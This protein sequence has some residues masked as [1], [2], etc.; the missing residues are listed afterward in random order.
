[1]GY[2][3]MELLLDKEDK[4]RGNLSKNNSINYFREGQVYEG[5]FSITMTGN[6][7]LVF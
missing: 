3:R 2:L 1:M 5:I 4:F 7:I 6:G